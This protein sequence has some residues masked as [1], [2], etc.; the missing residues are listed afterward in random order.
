[1]LIVEQIVDC[2]FKTVYSLF[3]FD[4]SKHESNIYR[5]ESTADI[6][7]KL[8]LDQIPA[9]PYNIYCVIFS[10]R[11]AIMEVIDSKLYVNI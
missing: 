3:C 1:M 9:Y 8:L 4:V 2:K 7:I 6:E 5:S 11:K 10:E